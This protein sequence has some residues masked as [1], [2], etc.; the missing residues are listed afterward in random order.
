[1]GNEALR[2]VFGA[3]ASVRAL[4]QSYVEFSDDEVVAALRG[5]ERDLADV[6]RQ[7]RFE[8]QLDSDLSRVLG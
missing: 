8:R 5:I 4:R 6:V 7:V 1:M 3:M 2:A